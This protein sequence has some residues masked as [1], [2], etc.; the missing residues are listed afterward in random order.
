M[1]SKTLLVAQREYIE[2]IRTKTFWIGIFIV[3]VLIAASIG[4]GA[5]LRELKEVQRYAVVDLSGEG[6][7]D[8]AERSFRS[9]DFSAILQAI[10]KQSKS[11]SLEDELTALAASVG[12]V[13]SPD[14]ITAD[15][16]LALLN[17]IYDQPAEVRSKIEGI[18][19]SKRYEYVDPDELGITETESGALL[20]ELTK[21]VHRG[22]L[23]GFFVLGEDPV[24][25]YD[26]F[27]FVS[28]N[29]TDDALPKSYQATVTE[30]LRGARI[31]AAGIKR[32]VAERIQERV[33]FQKKK[34]TESGEIVDVD[35]EDIASQWAPVGFVYL[36]WIAIFSIA[37]LLLTNT[38]E[39]KS[40]RIIE[41]LLSSVSPSELMHGKIYG[42]ALTGMTIIGTWVIFALLASW[43]APTLLGD[44]SG[45]LGF[46]IAAISNT[47]YLTGFVLYFLGGYLLYAAVLVAIG[48]VCNTLKE[49]QNLIQPVMMILFVP[50]I[51]MVF[52]TQEPN[53]TVAKVLSYVPIYTPFTMMNRA[54]GP[55]ETWEYVVTSA[56]LVVTI[57]LT[58]KAA[59]KVFR[60]GVLMTGNPP[61]LKEILG[62]LWKS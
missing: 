20:R 19:A 15:Q 28:D 41:V 45:A 59:G 13:E 18:S 47:G 48:S 7:A 6:L 54:A 9:G 43:L 27:L 40:N 5:L 62:W 1:A 12:E 53:G 8:R 39:E 29:Q 44:D 10:Q 52:I 11:G 55:P 56:L 22:D 33:V 36:L 35:G 3:P 46:I 31:R 23:F 2:N 60:V 26:D 57:L 49:A 16:Q 61:R 17:W 4:I 32:S 37:N 58:F 24:G 34:S 21:A 51:A 25:S 42:I 30:L 14:D 50:L 38:V